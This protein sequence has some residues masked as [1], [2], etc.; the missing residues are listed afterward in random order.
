MSTTLTLP[1]AASPLY[2]ELTSRG[3][4][5]LVDSSTL[6]RALYSS[7][8]SLYRLVPEAVAYPRTVDE[9]VAVVDAARASGTPLTSRGA[10]TSC[11]GNAVGPGLVVDTRRH[12][13]RVLSIDAAA[14][15]ATVQP[16]TVH[17]MLQLAAT[18]QGLRFGPDPSTHTRCTVGGMVG[19]NAC[20]PRAMGYGRTA[21]NVVAAEIVC[22]NGERLRVV[23]GESTPAS[24]TLDRLR[25]LVADNLALI[26]TEFGRFGRQVSG[27]SLEHLLPERGFDVARFLAGT[28]GTLAVFTELTM[29][30][31]AD[32]PHKAMVALGYA[33]MADAGDDAVVLARHSP[34]AAEGLDRRIVNV[35]ERAKGA[36]SVPRLPNGDGW[37]LVELVDD[38]PVRLRERA[39]ALLA[40]ANPID[41]WVV[42][43]PA[44]ALALWKIREDGAGLAGVSLERPAYGG[45]EDAAV[46]PEKLGAYL[47]DFDAL[48][49]RHGLHGLPYGHFGDG[50]VHCR[51]D[52]PLEA[53]GGA[54]AYR[55]F[56]EEAA[57]LVA[58]FGGSMSGEHGDGRARSALLPRM[59]S[60]EAI[61][62]MGKVKTIFDPENLL[63]PGV[64]V[65]P[66]PVEGDLRV[67]QIRQK[68]LF[69]SDPHLVEQVHQ[70]SGVGKCLAD[71]TAGGQ[72][73]CPS[74]LATGEEKD[75]TR[76]RARVLQELVNG[77][78]VTGWESPEVHQALDLC[79]SCKG[80]YR[81]CPTGIDMATYKSIATDRAFA[82]KLR[83]RAHYALGWL[84]RWGRL[85]G[86]TRVGP[87]VNL[88]GRLPGISAVLKKTAGVDRRRALPRFAAGSNRARAEAPAT[89]GRPVAVWVD[90]FSDCFDGGDLEALLEVLVSAGWAPQVVQRNACCG[91]TWIST[92][93]R[94][95]ARRQLRDAVEVLHPLVAAG[96]PIVG[97]E[98]SCTAV[99]RT[100]ALELLPDDP[101]VAELAS[102]ILTL[103]ELLTRSPEWQ[104][105][106]LRGVHVV[107]QPHCH[108]AS[109]L[110][111]KTDAALLAR[112]GAEVTTVGGCCGLAG[113]FGVEEGHYEVS[114]AVAE[115]DLLP[116][117]RGAGAGAVVLADGFSCRLQLDE[118]EGRSAVTL[119]ELLSSAARR[120]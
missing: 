66:R 14:R 101:R 105:P 87:L 69:R 24:P 89:S 111:W 110:G 9:L 26:R 74:Y 106:D 57:D 44:E 36:G 8:A 72:V 80:C 83:P 32:A 30:L 103:A 55:A 12:L 120:P 34:T 100:D 58:S 118:L 43:D 21:D 51:I 115:H 99:W 108:H 93:Q 42:A 53:D 20:G 60:A 35:V 29:R 41:G 117:V 22:G 15:T 54:E 61:A 85:I 37:M 94:E 49:K 38:D 5:E 65:D 25:E 10:G 33:S 98:P 116:A 46:P 17:A 45:W 6:A 23:S 86:A 31:V 92:G 59:Y 18:A 81:D 77:E 63:N 2:A 96:V 40:D 48:L 39:D 7:D 88:A 47:R 3:L 52:F 62:L 28:E 97:V 78:L 70:C 67:P 76:G 71:S 79:L 4:A 56:V 64:L 112:T 90:S 91:L 73:M 107:A 95:G 27:Y 84:P 104:V 19:N 1:F 16:G 75:S 68:S 102:G 113:N 50:C 11:A 114:V 13:H 109:V 82:G 119:A